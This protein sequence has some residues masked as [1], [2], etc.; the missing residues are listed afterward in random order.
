MTIRTILIVV[1][2]VALAAFLVPAII[3]FANSY[4]AGAA[5]DAQ[6]TA[7]FIPNPEN[8]TVVIVR[9]WSQ[10]DMKRILADFLSAYQLRADSTQ[11]SAGADDRITLT[12]PNDIQPKILYFLVNYI[13]YPK[14][15]DLKR[16]SI[17]AVAHVVL[18]R[19]FGVPE[20]RLIGKLADIY[21]PANDTEY[22]L[23][24]AKV[25]SGEVYKISFTDLIWQQVK[26]ARMPK[27]IVGM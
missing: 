14:D 25:D 2:V 5:Q 12:F 3:R 26:S 24:Y 22:D 11:I 17:G 9:G 7:V 13:Q 16:R 21:V 20:S 8:K 19:S 27:D 1:V 4:R 6:M 15:F 18:N 10:A 23:V